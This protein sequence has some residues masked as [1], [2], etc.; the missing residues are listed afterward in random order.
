MK[1]PLLGVDYYPEHWPADRW[2]TDA[3]MMHAAGLS[4]VRIGEFAWAKMEPT[5]GRYDWRWLDEALEALAAEGLQVVLGTPTST[6]PAWLIQKHPDILPVDAQGRR[7]NFGSRR[8]YCS[9]NATYHEYTRRIVTALAHRY[10]NHPAVIGWQLDNEFGCHDT[11]RCYCENCAAAFRVWLKDK[12]SSLDA[13]NAAWGAVF[14][15]QSYTDWAQISPPN[16]TVTEANSS[17]V[18]DWYR[19][20]SDSV[21]AY[22]QI[23][24]SILRQLAPDRFITTNFMGPFPDLDYYQ[25]SAPLDFI[26]WNSYPTGYA[27]VTGPTLYMPD[28]PRPKLAYDVG[29]PY[30]TGFC[31]DLMR[32]LKDGLPY[33]VMEQQAGS[34]NWANTNPGIRPGTVRLWTW[35]DLAAGADTVVY[36]RWRACLYAQE[37]Y[38][39]GLLRHDAAPDLGYREVLRM[40]D[41]Q[42]LMRSI[43]GARVQVDVAILADYDDLWALDL[44]PHNHVIAYWRHL[45]AYHRALVRAGVPTDVVSKQADLSRYKLVI[46]PSL[47]LAD[48]VWAA[49]LTAYVKA[50]GTLVLGV[51]SGFKTPSNLVTD[52][53]LPGPFRELVGAT[54]EAWHSL[55]PGVTYPLTDHKHQM[56]TAAIWAEGLSTQ[57]A[58]PLM[59]YTGGPLEG[60]AAVTVKVVGQGRAVYAGVWPDEAVLNSLISWL[61]PQAGVQPLALLPE[62]VLVSRRGSFVF[63]FNF[64]DAPATAWLN[65]TSAVDAFTGQSIERA[66]AIAARDVRVLSLG[67][68]SR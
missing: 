41:E 67:A 52:Q 24:I 62:G 20:S 11:A 40:K 34:I 16:L 27:E 5:E 60:Q 35:H 58:Q 13:L 68:D 8:H 55:P 54:V 42:P 29:D 30:V 53:P 48:D 18:L 43:Q 15:S 14:W 2:A 61:L 6:P 36:F 59:F 63:L 7:R 12:Y 33:W 38:H 46:A 49:R 32:G 56:L 4:V 51:R 1:P 17:H 64:T 22:A 65:V 66:A 28:E 3:R 9:N 19:F 31:H 47:L 23:Q 45:F 25:L 26:A 37:Q 21:V 10:G 57:S 44:Q 39:S 50:G